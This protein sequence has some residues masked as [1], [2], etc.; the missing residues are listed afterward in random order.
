M[1][2]WALFKQHRGA[3]T[4][5][6]R[7]TVLGVSVLTKLP[8]LSSSLGDPQNPSFL[9]S[10]AWDL[11]GQILQRRWRGVGGAGEGTLSPPSSASGARRDL[12]GQRPGGLRLCV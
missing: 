8:F 3:Y 11:Q 7:L 9:S 4:S 6:L 10:Q 2:M 1:G 12:G 5:L